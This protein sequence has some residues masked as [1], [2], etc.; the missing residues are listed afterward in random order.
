VPRV[1]VGP[2]GT[3]SLSGIVAVDGGA[4][5]SAALNSDGTVWTFGDNYEGE[6]GNGT[7]AH[8]Q[9]PVRVVGPGGTGILDR[10]VAIQAGY[11]HGLALRDDG[12]VWTWGEGLFG[13]LGTGS[14]TRSTS[15]VQPV[16]LGGTGPLG[17]VMSIA[18]NDDYSNF[19][20]LDE[21]RVVGWGWND[22]G[23]M[24]EATADACGSRGCKLTPMLI[25]TPALFQ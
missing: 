25:G 19:V 6:L 10:V 22:K 13:E 14:T 20:L 7:I 21:G 4:Y 2:G 15:P 16:G 17:G 3:G 11:S 5:H 18:I 9:T 8:A 23:E 24:G 12:T 1:V